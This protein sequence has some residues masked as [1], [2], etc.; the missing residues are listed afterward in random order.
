VVVIVGAPELSA[1][2]GNLGQRIQPARIRWLI[3]GATALVFVA[4]AGLRC[5]DLVTNR[6]Y[7]STADEA[8]FGAGLCSW[9]PQ[10]A[11]EFVEREKLPG[12]TLSTYAAG[13]YLAWK[14]GPQR[15]V[16]I[17]GRDTLY[18]PSHLARHSQLMFSPPDSLV[19]QQEVSRYNINTVVLALARA[20]GLQ[21][22][23]LRNLC[24][25]SLWR[26]VYL[27]ERSAVFVRQSP[28]NQ[29]LIQRFPLDCAKTPLPAASASAKRGEAFNT[30][31][32]AAITL[33]A[34]GRN[35]EALAAY[36]RALSIFSG[37][38]LLH[39]SYADLLFSMG[40]LDESE[41]EY[42]TAV[43]LEPSADTWGALAHTYLQRGR[44]SAGTEAMEH[45][46]QFSPRSYLTLADLGY[47][48]LNLKRPENALRAFERA[49]RATP[50]SLRAADNGFFECKVAQGLAAAWDA[51]GNLEKATAYQEEATKL[52]PDLPQ[53]W[54]RLARLYQ[55]Q[56]RDQDANLARAHATK[57]QA[58]SDR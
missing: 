15:R 54:L 1:A 44:I 13:G 3:A 28:E 35:P 24:S 34:L 41:K 17:D 37:S 46:V 9:F 27:D 2:I 53:P 6:H 49:A 42:L 51:L 12:E 45:E 19:W 31:T 48:Y 52:Q 32:N 4:L 23:L 11:A 43:A 18:G 20:D 26:P 57:L 47:L 38:A 7:Y 5:F 29:Q 16:Y 14:L 25:S 22:A 21:P 55:L 10:R 8:V 58:H 40:R 56:G 39:R 33:A 50:G 36:Q 30:W